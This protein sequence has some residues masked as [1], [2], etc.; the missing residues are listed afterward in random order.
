METKKIKKVCFFSPAS[1]PFFYPGSDVSHGG[2]EL[3]MYLWAKSLLKNQDFQI[4]FLTEKHKQEKPLKQS[5]IKLIRTIKLKNNEFI[6]SKL[7]KSIKYFFQ[8]LKLNPDVIIC[9]NANAILG[10]TGF[11]A[12]LFH[13]KFIY[14]TSSEIDVKLKIKNIKICEKSIIILMLL[15]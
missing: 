13:K 1:Y 2:A 8:L 6:L 7:L 11:Y 5:D 9:T 3:Q 14:R 15:F 4:Y 10:I 12:K